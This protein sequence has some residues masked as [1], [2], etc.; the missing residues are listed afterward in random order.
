MSFDEMTRSG[1]SED[2]G[3]EDS[4][5]SRTSPQ[6]DR[7]KAAEYLAAWQRC[8]ADFINFKRRAEQERA[9][10][11]NAANS[12]LL[13]AILP[14]LDDLERAFAAMPPELEN[15]NWVSGIRLIW[16]KLQSALE[17]QGLSHLKC[18]GEVFDPCLHEAV[19]QCKG[20]EG[21]VVQEMEKG[22]KYRE[23][24]IRPSRVAVGEGEQEYKEE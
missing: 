18:V 15:A 8:Q 3:A 2:S 5:Q 23:K 10:A 13:M 1:E 12:A 17:A 22:Y 6:D 21:T 24:L 9:E 19:R 14:A 11:G 20:P 4:G 16:R 7:Q